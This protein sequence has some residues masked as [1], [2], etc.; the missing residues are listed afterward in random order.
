MPAIA[1]LVPDQMVRVFAA[2][3]DFCY[4]VHRSVINESMLDDIDCAVQR[5]H[6]EQEI[7]KE[8]EVCKHF[9]LPWQHSMIHYHSLI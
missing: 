2:F 8:T 1:G 5:F 4:L 9:S 3:L 6:K 7:F